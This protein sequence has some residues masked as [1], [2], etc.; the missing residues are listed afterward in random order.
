MS[1]RQRIFLN[2]SSHS[3]RTSRFVLNGRGV[4]DCSSMHLEITYKGDEAEMAASHFYPRS[5][6]YALIDDVQIIKNGREVSYL[7]NVGAFAALKSMTVRDEKRHSAK[8]KG[9]L[10][11][12]VPKIGEARGYLTQSNT[13]SNANLL[14]AN[15]PQY[16][17]SWADVNLNTGSNPLLPLQFI[18]QIFERNPY[19]NLDV[20]KYEIII[21]WASS[22]MFIGNAPSFEISPE[23]RLIYE[24]NVNPDVVKDVPKM[25]MPWKEVRAS[26]FIIPQ[27]TAGSADTQLIPLR[28]SNFDAEAL[29]IQFNISTTTALWGTG[30]SVPFSIGDYEINLIVNDSAIYS[31]PITQ[32]AMRVYHLDRAASVFGTDVF[33]LPAM[34]EFTYTQDKT[35]VAAA[36]TQGDPGCFYRGNSAHMAPMVTSGN[37]V[38]TTSPFHY[39]GF[40]LRNDGLPT[41][42]NQSGI[43]LQLIRSGSPF[44]IPTITGTAFAISRRA[45]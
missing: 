1:N 19:L 27:L 43:F 41:F 9:S 5:G 33:K 16:S 30:H 13:Q 3:K 23:T 24:T 40:D 20:D 22:N 45:E 12:E 8:T 17:D 2:P 37:A 7:N 31:K 39:L 42:L 32:E 28:L 35:A 36:I 44:E 38:A 15:Y 14:F 10:S 29:F 26:T 21:N 34:T 6:A 4:L 25:L 11:F 18:M